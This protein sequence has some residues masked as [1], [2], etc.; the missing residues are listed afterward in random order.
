MEGSSGDDSLSD[1]DPDDGLNGFFR[2]K[3]LLLAAVVLLVG[4][5][6]RVITV[7][8]NTIRVAY[9][10]SQVGCAVGFDLFCAAFSL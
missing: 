9:K 2:T 3:Q 1:G 4:L 5:A 8:S 6:Y 10:C 7:S